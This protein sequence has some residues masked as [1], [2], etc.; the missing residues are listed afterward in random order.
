[1]WEKLRKDNTE[2][3]FKAELEEE[4][5]DKEGNVFNRKVFEDLKRQG[6]L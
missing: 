5:E 1:L 2:S 6:L 3:G 4:F